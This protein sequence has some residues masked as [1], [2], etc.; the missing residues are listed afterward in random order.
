MIWLLLGVLL[1]SG[2]HLV[3]SVAVPV[4]TGLVQRLGGEPRLPTCHGWRGRPIAIQSRTPVRWVRRLESIVR[5]GSPRKKP[6]EFRRRPW[7]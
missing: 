2:V 6:R 3:P 7:Q 4:K 1:W 5:T